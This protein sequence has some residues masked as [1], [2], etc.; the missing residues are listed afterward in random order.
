[1]VPRLVTGG[2]LAADNA[3]S[4][5]TALRPML[6]RAMRDERVDSVL[7]PMKAF[8]SAARSSRA[9]LIPAVFAGAV[10]CV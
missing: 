2:L 8:C 6:D 5:Q 4:H 7:V 10:C 3:I 9:C 1:V